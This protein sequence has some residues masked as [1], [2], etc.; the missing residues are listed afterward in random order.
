MMAKCKVECVSMD[1][2]DQGSVPGEELGPFHTRSVSA[3]DFFYHSGDT[4]CLS[5]SF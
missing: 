2:E 1:T 3:P 5:L 4:I